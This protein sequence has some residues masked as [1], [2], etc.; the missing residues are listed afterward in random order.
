MTLRPLARY[1][2]VVATFLS[3]ASLVRAEADAAGSAD[4]FE[5]T[6]RPILI[7]RCVECHGPDNAESDLRLDSKEAFA[8]GGARGEPLVPGGDPKSGLFRQAIRHENDLEM[9]PSGKLPEE[10]L[11]ALERWIEAGAPWPES[12]GGLRVS[13]IEERRAQD[14]AQHWAYQPVSRPTPPAVADAGRAVTPIDQFLIAKLEAKGLAYSPEADRYTL[15]RRASFDLL[16]LP[17]TYEEVQAFEKDDRPDAWERAI[18][19]LLASPRYG[20]RWGR[21]WLDVARYADTSGYAFQRD[22][23]YPYAFTYRDYVVRSLNQDLP[24]DRFVQEQLAADLLP[25]PRGPDALAALGFLTVGRDFNNGQDNLDDKI[26]VVSRGLLGLTVACARCHDHKY[27]AIA[28]GDY[29]SWYG[30]FASSR[31]PDELPLIVPERDRDRYTDFFA[32]LAERQK[33]VE[34]FERQLHTEIVDQAYK[35]FADYV[36]RTQYDLPAMSEPRP[37]GLTMEDKDVRKGML[38][39]F[40][41]WLTDRR[42][43][44][45]SPF[46]PLLQIVDL[47]EAEFAAKL[48]QMLASWRAE[49]G[50]APADA[51]A[52]QA[53]DAEQP[54]ALDMKRTLIERFDAKMPGRRIDAIFVAAKAY[55]ELIESAR[56]TL[57][58]KAS[59]SAE[60]PVSTPA[61][62]VARFEPVVAAE[63]FPA[64]ISLEKSEQYRH[65]E[66]R[67]R[68]QEVQKKAKQ[69]E[70]D[71][72]DPPPRAMVLEQFAKHDPRVFK[73]GKPGNPGDIVP[74]QFVPVVAKA[75]AK[76]YE[77]GGRLELARDVASAENPLTARVIVNRVWMHHFGE[78]LVASPSD[79][80]IRTEKPVQAELLDYLAGRLIDSGWSLKVLH[81]EIMTSGAYRQVDRLDEKAYAADPEN[82]LFWRYERRRLEWEP[83]RDSVVV[84]AGRFDG[85][86]HGRALDLL[87]PPYPGRRSLY[88]SIDRQALPQT[89]RAFDIASPDQSSARRPETVVPQQAL[90]LMNSPFVQ[91]HADS[92]RERVCGSSEATDAR[93]SEL[94]RVALSRDPSSEERELCTAFMAGREGDASAWSELCQS[95]LMSSPFTFVD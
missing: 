37:E 86:M 76:P 74:R 62:I 91:T 70:A 90:F 17:P 51:G 6:V 83:F 35:S 13:S 40:G 69:F 45:G 67:N 22:N 24:Y 3:L 11:A 88:A 26:D 53:D 46:G 32:G 8:A 19:R 47:P 34:G 89:Y 75:D 55:Q 28:I 12:A 16:G 21:H 18:D 92:L 60:Q 85:A 82:R 93:I 31:Q 57:A 72:A 52:A 81:R 64:N 30:I 84:A 36:V 14:R 44:E 68:L 80:G 10:E 38:D 65:R 27:D 2:A 23:R 1:C 50:A 54:P 94:F 7:A 49:V 77:T 71:Y 58:A 5:S 66:D 61:P 20:E 39:R 43:E 42:K 41:A 63:N 78:P 9:P 95:V 79:F 4:F 48:A 29:Y 56:A 59:G 33:E 25:D 73:R 15:L 87:K